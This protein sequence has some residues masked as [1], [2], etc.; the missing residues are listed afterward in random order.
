MRVYTTLYCTVLYTVSLS[1]TS[2]VDKGCISFHSHSVD[3][4]VYSCTANRVDVR[5]DVFL[6]TI[7]RVDMEVFSCPPPAVGTW[8][9]IPF[10]LTQCGVSLSVS[11]AIAVLTHRVY[12][13]SP[14]AVWTCSV[15]IHLHHHQCGR[16]ECIHLRRKQCGRA[17]LCI[18]V[19]RQQSRRARCITHSPSPAIYRRGAGCILLH[20]HAMFLNAGM[21]DCT[22]SDQSGTGMTM[23]EAVYQNKGSSGTRLR[24]WGP[25]YLCRRHW[26]RCRCP[27]MVYYAYEYA[28]WLMKWGSVS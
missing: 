16:A 6:S 23:P 3:A 12:P 21:S 13:F 11:T 7:N 4:R 18:S 2:S 9:R 1:N 22:A 19:P 25:E 14:L 5:M 10:C 27:A 17:S 28:D 15:C 8:G 26:S 24:C 20:L